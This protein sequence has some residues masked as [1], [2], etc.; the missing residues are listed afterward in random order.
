MF[1]SIVW[2]TAILPLAPATFAQSDSCRAC[3]CQF[4]NVEVLDQLIEARIRDMLA[5]DTTVIQAIEERIRKI[6]ANDGQSTQ[7]IESRIRHILANDTASTQVIQDR[8]INTLNDG[9]AS[10]QTLESRITNTVESN[11]GKPPIQT[12]NSHIILYANTIILL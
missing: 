6:L 5:N 10:T 8:I 3:N 12:Y 11:L 9:T 4:N 2:F 1:L 7:V